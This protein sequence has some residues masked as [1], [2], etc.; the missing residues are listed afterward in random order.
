[1]GWAFLWVNVVSGT[2]ARSYRTFPPLYSVVKRDAKLVLL[3]LP[4]IETTNDID[5]NQIV[6]DV[7]FCDKVF[8]SVIM[9]P[10][11]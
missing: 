8:E 3:F 10:R 1:M 6:I 9:P 2:N 11:P 5:V 7:I 4:A